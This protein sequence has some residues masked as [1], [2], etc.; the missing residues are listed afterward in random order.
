MCAKLLHGSL[1]ISELLLIRLY[2]MS[3]LPVLFV[4][5]DVDGIE[6]GCQW[7]HPELTV[8]P[9]CIWFSVFVVLASL[10]QWMTNSYN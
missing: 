3:R 5:D 8:F 9:L 1:G 2:P 6:I 10:Y 7:K 4:S